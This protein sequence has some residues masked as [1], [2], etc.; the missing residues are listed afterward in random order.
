MSPDL[1]FPLCFIFSLVLI[2]LYM[3]TESCLI[4]LWNMANRKTLKELTVQ[5]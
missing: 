3:F 1:D 2:L 4:I 5:C